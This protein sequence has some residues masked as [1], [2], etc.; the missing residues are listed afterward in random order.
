MRPRRDVI[1][2][3]PSAVSLHDSRRCHTATVRLLPTAFGVRSAQHQGGKYLQ[4]LTQTHLGN[5]Q[6]LPITAAKQRCRP[7]I[8]LVT[9]YYAPSWHR[10]EEVESHPRRLLVSCASNQLRFMAGEKTDSV[11]GSIREM[12]QALA[13]YRQ[14]GKSGLRISVPIVRGSIYIHDT[15]D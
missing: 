9:S 15:H 6:L 12:S 8:E 14:L 4:R 3:V 13:E 1:A 2:A 11:P 5:S 7:Q 10:R